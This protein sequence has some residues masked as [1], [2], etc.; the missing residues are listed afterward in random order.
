MKTKQIPDDLRNWIEVRTFEIGAAI[1][2]PGC[3]WIISGEPLFANPQKALPLAKL[4]L[5]PMLSAI[6]KLEMTQRSISLPDFPA[7]SCIR[8][9]D[10][11]M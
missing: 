3:P 1:V 2:L 7:L 5:K 10:A 9:H 4:P 6:W 8:L 11:T